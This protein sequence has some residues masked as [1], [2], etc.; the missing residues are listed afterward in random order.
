M[1]TLVERTGGPSGRFARPDLRL[2]FAAISAPSITERRRGPYPTPA[3]DARAQVREFTPRAIRRGVMRLGALL[4]ASMVTGLAA[5]HANAAPRPVRVIVPG[6][7]VIL[8]R[9]IARPGVLVGCRI[10]GHVYTTAA[11]PF[12]AAGGKDLVLRGHV[13]SLWL[14]WIT[15]RRLVFS[16]S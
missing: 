6:Q 13:H 8:L 4:F 15:G 10:R 9:P 11:P 16:C 7:R 1:T 5:V 14:R 2:S 3:R 12:Q